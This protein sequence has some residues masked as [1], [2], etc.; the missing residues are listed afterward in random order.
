[1]LA[2][3]NKKT[4]SFYI[5]SND[6]FEYAGKNQNVRL[7]NGYESRKCAEILQ[8][9]LQSRVMDIHPITHIQCE[10]FLSV[11][12]QP[13]CVMAFPL[14]GIFAII[15][16]RAYLFEVLCSTRWEWTDGFQTFKS[17][18]GTFHGRIYF[19]LAYFWFTVI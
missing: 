18:L 8:Y 10:D 5:H 7:L 4:N 15:A 3:N 6:V 17:P 16:K 13:I 9:F 14:L 2:D 1:M 11:A 19:L 12:L